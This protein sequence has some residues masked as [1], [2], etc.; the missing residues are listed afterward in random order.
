MKIET[1][2]SI[3]DI[4]C[5]FVDSEKRPL[6]IIQI[7]IKPTGVEYCLSDGFTNNWNYVFEFEKKYKD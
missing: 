4:V 7:C 6:I 1:K 3:G 2:Y 5:L